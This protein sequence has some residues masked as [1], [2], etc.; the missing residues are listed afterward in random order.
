VSEKSSATIDA[1]PT[2]DFGQGSLAQYVYTQLRQEIHDRQLASGDR[3]READIAER[4]TVSRTPVREALKRLEAEGVVRFAPPRGFVVV[5][6]SPKQV[7]E[8]YA[9][10]KVMVGAAARFAA[11]QASPIEILSMQQVIA[12]LE[13]A[14]SPDEVAS[15]NRRLHE[16]IV[17]AAHNEYLYKTSNVLIDALGLLGSTTYSMP[18]RIKS[19]LKENKEI[20]ACIARHDAD[21]AERAAHLHVAAA[22][23][24]RLQMLFGA[25]MNASGSQSGGNA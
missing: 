17:A 20:V 22:T 21:G 1:E 6:L 3:L 12:K 15:L 10:R 14:K 5:Q 9:M 2:A 7:M 4:L 11:E 13:R 19:G 24:L 16:I 18:G 23:A 25:E 8:L